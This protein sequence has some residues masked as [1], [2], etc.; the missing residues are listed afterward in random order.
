MC[1]FCSS[2]NFSGKKKNETKSKQ[3]NVTY[4]KSSW[5]VFW[6]FLMCQGLSRE[7]LGWVF[8]VCFQDAIPNFMCIQK[9][10]RFLCHEKKENELTLSI[11]VSPKKGITPKILL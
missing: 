7:G 10:P 3:A 2:W 11:Q 4:P 1:G 9:T 6:L 5:R 8:S